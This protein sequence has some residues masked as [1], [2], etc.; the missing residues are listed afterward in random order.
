MT[1]NSR[2]AQELGK[3]AEAQGRADAFH[4][5]VFQAYFVDGHN[6]AKPEVLQKIAQRVGLDGKQALNV[7]DRR[8]YKEAVDCDRQRAMQMGINAVPTF[9][10]NGRILVGAQSDDALYRLVTGKD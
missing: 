8:S 3:W 9:R 2:N 4:Q 5:A 7:L 10:M 1:Y 6:I